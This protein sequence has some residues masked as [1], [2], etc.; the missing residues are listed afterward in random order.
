MKNI[1][2]TE[3]FLIVII[4]C[5]CSCNDFLKDLQEIEISYD[6]SELVLSLTTDKFIYSIDEPVKITLTVN[7]PTSNVIKG[8]YY[9]DWDY[10]VVKG[11]YSVYRL[12][13]GDIMWPQDIL[14]GTPYFPSKVT[15]YEDTWWQN[16][17]N[18]NPVSTGT[19]EIRAKLGGRNSY[20][21]SGE[22][23]IGKDA[24][25]VEINIIP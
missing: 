1:N 5:L 13:E 10:T 24:D 14:D 21:L 19:Y 17:S 15:E 4:F 18:G 25:P 23:I 22:K 9:P 12:L 16:D 3:I 2:L 6:T 8:P 20:N 7:N 11:T